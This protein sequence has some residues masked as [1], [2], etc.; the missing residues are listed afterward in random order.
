MEKLKDCLPYSFGKRLS[1]QIV[2][3]ML[4][5]NGGF[6]RVVE[7]KLCSINSNQTEILVKELKTPQFEYPSAVLRSSDVDCIDL[8]F[9]PNDQ[10]SECY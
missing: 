5:F 10:Q 6:K 2:G 8:D 7:G 4:N 3:P 1:I 9:E